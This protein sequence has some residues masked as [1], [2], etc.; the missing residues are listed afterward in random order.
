MIN[1]IFSCPAFL[2][3]SGQKDKSLAAIDT[4]GFPRP[5]LLKFFPP[6][7]SL[8]RVKERWKINKCIQNDQKCEIRKEKG[9]D[10]ENEK[11]TRND[12]KWDMEGKTGHKAEDEVTEI[13][14]KNFLVVVTECSVSWRKAHNVLDHWPVTSA[15][16]INGVLFQC[17]SNYSPACRVP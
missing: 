9:T 17:S 2:S 15:L 10:K 3:L 12:E 16:I 1:A 4:R 11:K 14:L 7:P 13:W 8:T 6:L 5:L